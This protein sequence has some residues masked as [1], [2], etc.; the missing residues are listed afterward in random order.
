V[1]VFGLGAVLYELLAGQPPFLGT[2]LFDTLSRTRDQDPAAPSRL[3]RGVPRDLETICLKCL[4]KDPARRYG[5][6][7]E[8]AAELGRFLEGRPI[9]GRPVPAGERLL[10]WAKRRPAVAALTAA[11]VLVAACGVGGAAYQWLQTAA[12][13]ERSESELYRTQI[14][15]AFRHLSAGDLDDADEALKLCPPSF[16]SWEWHYLKRRAQPEGFVLRGHK[17]SVLSLALSPDG[18]FLASGGA[19]RTARLWDVAGQGQLLACPHTHPVQSVAYSRAG[20]LLAWAGEDMTVQVWDVTTDRP[21]RTL[22]QAG[23]FVALS[24]DGRRLAAGGKGAHITVWDVPSFRK[25]A[26]VPHGGEVLCLAFSPDGRWLA[27]GGFGEQP[28][29]VWDAATLRPGKPLRAA[30]PY[31]VVALAFSSDSRLLAAADTN[32]AIIWDVGT[33]EH[34]NVLQGPNSRCTSIAFSPDGE[35]VAA[36]FKSSPV[37]VWRLRDKRVVFTTRRHAGNVSGVAFDPDPASPRLMFAEGAEIVVERWRGDTCPEGRTLRGP[38]AGPLASL[39]AG[40]RLAAGAGDGTVEVWDPADGKLLWTQQ[41]HKGKVA[42]LA[43][44]PDDQLLAG[45]GDDGTVT[46]WQAATGE[47]VHTLTGHTAAVTAVAFSPDGRRLASACR[48]RTVKV[49]DVASG[50]EAF[51]LPTHPA[52][53]FGVAFSPDG[54][55]LAAAYDGGTLLV[56]DLA[57][58]RTALTLNDRTGT[59]WGVAFSPDG[60]LLATANSDGLVKIWQASSGAELR[61]LRGHRGMVSGVAFSPDGRRLVSAGLDGTVRVWDVT[62][63]HELLTLGGNGGGVAAVAFSRPHGHLLASVGEDGLIGLW[64]ATPLEEGGP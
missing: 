57:A 52:S 20:P 63:G 14:A 36:S 17:G 55:R 7:R 13:L 21:L 51:T 22:P 38:P 9:R 35:Y 31:W 61:T 12:A 6:A 47:L 2:D 59:L 18:R 27:S 10:K 53:V 3:R 29:R 11:L 42:G 39:A 46:L 5:S 56:W 62:H 28:V 25:L 45:G 49:W 1:D 30:S 54:K 58:R 26:D 64:D 23:T 37:T 33:G 41:A 16:R 50:E 60:R 44:S 19:D 43:F 8:L 40:R 32:S 34:V 15:L 48:D 24:P 4:Q